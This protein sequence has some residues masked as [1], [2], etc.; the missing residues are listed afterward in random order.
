MD[1]PYPRYPDGDDLSEL[2]LENLTYLEVAFVRIDWKEERAIGKSSVEKLNLNNKAVLIHTGWDKYRR[3]EA[4]F[5]GHPYLIED[6]VEFISKSGCKLVAIDPY[7]ID[8]TRDGEGPAH[9]LLLG[10]GIPIIEHICSHKPFLHKKALEISA[11][12]V[13]LKDFSAFP[14][15]AFA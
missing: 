14:V 9:T 13:K 10:A 6:S 8:D 7:H 3:T 2:K 12:P 4:Y 5:S 11:V 15:R 1:S